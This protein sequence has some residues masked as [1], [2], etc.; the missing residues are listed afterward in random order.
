MQ[1]SYR[2]V[3]DYAGRRPNC[4]HRKT[5]E[6]VFVRWYNQYCELSNP[7]LEAWNSEYDGPSDFDEP[8]SVYYR[9]IA[10]KENVIADKITAL[11][12]TDR[13][14]AGIEKFYVSNECVFSALLSNGTHMSFHLE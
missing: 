6:E 4:L 9:Y 11:S 14:K 10:K 12:S 8:D 13:D 2:A 3:F 7:C 5:V 1:R